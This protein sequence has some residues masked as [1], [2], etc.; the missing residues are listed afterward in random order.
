MR[1]RASGPAHV[2][3]TLRSGPQDRVLKDGNQSK[4]AIFSPRLGTKQTELASGTHTT[5]K[6]D[7]AVSLAQAQAIVDRLGDVQT[8]GYC[9]GA[10][11]LRG[12]RRTQE[13]GLACRLWRDRARGL[14]GDARPLSAVRH[15][16][17][18]LLDGANRQS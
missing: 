18:L 6:P 4:C 8:V 9:Q 1:L 3:L 16:G 14:A 5:V 17:T 10:L 13:G 2:R 12:Q 7:I 11:L 15:A